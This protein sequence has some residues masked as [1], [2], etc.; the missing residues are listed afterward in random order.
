MSLSLPVLRALC[1]RSFYHF[2]KIVGGSVGQGGVISPVIHK[3]LCDFYQDPSIHRK[4]I[5]M[6]RAWLKSTVFTCWGTVWRYLQ[7]NNHRTLIASQNDDNAKR[8]LWFIQHQFRNNDLLR[9]LYPELEQVN[10]VW[11]KRHR[12]SAKCVE[13]PRGIPFKEGTI[14]SIGVT[15]AAQSGHYDMIAIDDPVG[16]KH[17]DSPTELE[18]VFRWHDNTSELLDNPNPDEPTASNITIICTHWGVGD[19]GHY[20]Q[21]RCPEYHWRIVPCLKDEGLEDVGNIKYIQDP[22]AEH[23]KSNWENAP[24]GKSTTQYYLDMMNDPERQML[25][26]SQHMNNPREGGTLNK[27]DKKWIKYYKI[28]KRGKE[29][30]FI[31]EDDGEEIPL[32][33]V[34]LTGMI[35][36]GGFSEMKLMKKGSRNAVL[37]GGQVRQSVK[38]F[39]TYTWAGRFKKPS[40]FRAEVFKAHKF[41]KPRVWRIDTVGTQPYIMKDLREAAKTD[42][43][44]FPIVEIPG[45]PRKDSKFDDINALIPVL[46]NGE[47]YFHRSMRELISEI[48]NYPHGMTVDLLDMLAKL[49]KL[50]WRKTGPEKSAPPSMWAK[51]MEGRSSVTGY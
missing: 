47:V 37:I 3:P 31:T 11:V 9:K 13:L 29:T 28:E 8:F 4:A 17:I 34:P 1:D 12:W 40:D 26:W 45:N 10:N 36:P 49:N 30:Y 16:Q 20:V 25:F 33:D 39:V 5:F 27:F 18:K 15:G 24:E 51:E 42:G 14:T 44:H 6:P 22:N 38:K 48:V 2:V 41:Q 50:Y 43:L 46:A 21:E 32:D 7:S 19:Y 23:M 35:D